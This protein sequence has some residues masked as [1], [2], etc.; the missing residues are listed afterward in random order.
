MKR[1]YNNMSS[2][3]YNKQPFKKRKIFKP[4]PFRSIS[5]FA[6]NNRNLKN[7]INYQQT[8]S[9]GE[10]KSMDFC[11]PTITGNTLSPFNLNNTPQIVVIN[12]VTIGSSAW[13]RI[14]RKL[15]MKSIHLTGCFNPI[16]GNGT[17]I[18]TNA[19]MMLV[20]DKQTN[21]SLPSYDDMFRDQYNGSTDN[22]SSGA[23]NFLAG[24]N[25]NNRDR[26]EIIFDKRWILPPINLGE[27]GIVTCTADLAA[28]SFFTSLKNREVHFK[29]D[30]STGVIGDIATGGLYIV[31]IADATNG[32]QSWGLDLKGRLRY[33]DL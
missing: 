13:N 18:V 4:S 7:I 23:N 19:R 3:S 2:L 11:S 20:Y 8:R 28:F 26:F 27:P 21:G 31:T 14:G 22:N 24:I 1:K 29:S 16:T 17:D 9:G 32:N 33:S 30:T 15:S 25:L 5:M 10:I 12:P 6:N